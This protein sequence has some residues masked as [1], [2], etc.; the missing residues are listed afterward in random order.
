MT[1]TQNRIAPTPAFNAEEV[2]KDFPVLQQQFHGHPLVYLDSGASAQKPDSV[3]RAI[4]HYYRHDHANVHRGVYTLSER[5]TEAYEGA[6]EKVRGFLNANSVKEIINVRGTTEAINLVAQAYGRPKLSTGDEVVI[7]GMEHHSNIVPWQLLCEQVGA[8]LRVVPLNDAGE[9]VMEDYDK[10]LTPRTQIVAFTHVSNALGTINPIKE[11]ID[12]AH[13]VDAVV[14]IDGAQAVPHMKVDVQ[15]LDCDFYAF[16]AHKLFGPTGIGILYGKQNL[17]EQMPPWQGGGEMIRTVTFEKTEYHDL[18]Y[19]FEAG[20]PHIAG[21]VGLG[22]VVDY[23]ADID[24]A[25]VGQH[26][27]QLVQ[28]ARDLAKSR[29]QLR[30]IGNAQNR[31]SIF[32]FVL[33]G[34]HPHDIGTI[35]DREGIAIRTGHHCAMPVMHR[36]NVPATA[37][38]SFAMYNT[39]EDVDALFAGIDKVLKVFA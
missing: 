12:K 31:A 27:H 38:A 11:M 34:V 18:P 7:T 37:R 6:R 21:A 35:I 3:I 24:M 32:S 29:P 19:K 17:L 28:R 8:T 14:V 15:E 5:A 1:Q 16:S 33:E 26:E 4:D 25:A 20:T 10:L 30:V 9:L 2:R 22:A 36:Y 23:L 13:Q 39:L